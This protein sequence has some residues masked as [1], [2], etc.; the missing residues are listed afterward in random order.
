MKNKFWPLFTIS[1]LCISSALSVY[2]HHSYSDSLYGLNNLDQHAFSFNSNDPF[3]NYLLTLVTS[4]M[5]HA[6][7]Q[8][9]LVNASFFLILGYILEKKFGALRLL[10]ISIFVHITTLTM[11]AALC[12]LTLLSPASFHGMSHIVFGLLA[13]ACLKYQ[14]TYLY[15]TIIGVQF[16]LLI[17][18]M[19]NLHE[20]FSHL[21]G[22]ATGSVS[23]L[24]IKKYF[25]LPS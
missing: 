3:K 2:A 4:G 21:I 11:L 1:F 16:Y 19:S 15:L 13:L 14:K 7:L 9:F 23:Y 5:Y 20:G 17:A 6:R 8:H 25:P 10:L 22:F 18:G 12:K 24:L